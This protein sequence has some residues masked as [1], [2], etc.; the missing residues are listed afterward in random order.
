[1][2][3]FEKD[4]VLVNP[5]FASLEG[6][7]SE[8]VEASVQDNL[9]SRVSIYPSKRVD[10]E[11]GVAKQTKDLASCYDAGAE[12][13]KNDELEASSVFAVMRNMEGVSSLQPPSRLELL[14]Q[15][16]QILTELS[17]EKVSYSGSFI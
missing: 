5:H 4:Y 2:E 16:V 17:R 6:A 13:S 14:H 3:S 10:L 8:Y 12:K 1:M 7:F 9:T 11:V 15:Y